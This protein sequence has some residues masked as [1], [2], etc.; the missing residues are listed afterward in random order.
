MQL[1]CCRAAGCNK[2]VAIP[3]RYC[4]FHKKDYQKWLSENRP[5][6]SHARYQRRMYGSKEGKYQQFY[7]T[8]AWRKLSQQVLKNNPVCVACLSNGIIRKADV[9]DHIIPIRVDWTK[10]LDA[11]NLQ[12]LCNS[13][14]R[15]K[16]NKEVRKRKNNK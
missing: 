14:H 7:N 3:E 11:D 6:P 5:K 2:L 13:C 4:E 15:R 9:V 8:T 1:R 16:T 12:P 10:R